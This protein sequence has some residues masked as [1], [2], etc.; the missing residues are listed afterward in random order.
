[1]SNEI[2]PELTSEQQNSKIIVFGASGHAKVVIDIIEKQDIYSVESL[3]DDNSKLKGKEI[4][5]YT[6]IGGKNDLDFQKVKRVLVAIGDNS[7]RAEVAGYLTLNNF[8]LAE[9]VIHPSAQLA[10]GVTIGTGS[11]VMAGSVINSDTIIGQNTI[12]NTGARIDHDCV[13]GDTVHIAPSSTLCGGVTVG[14]LTL[15]GA[16]ATILPNVKVGRNVI[17]G[18]GSTV[19]EDIKDNVSV[20]GTPAEVI[21]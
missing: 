5:G 10:R 12:V 16:G 21:N 6:V 14:D 11:A 2:K 9:A 8:N 13:I 18:A 20:V 3:A 4:Y 19:L 1:M 17:V 15:I 7:V